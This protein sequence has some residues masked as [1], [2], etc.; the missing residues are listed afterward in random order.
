MTRPD[1]SRA[2]ALE[3]RS[4]LLL[5]IAV[6]VAF[7]WILRPF[8]GAVLWGVIIAIVFR[9]VYRRVLRSMPERPTLAALATVFVI[10]VLVILP[11][12]LVAGMLVQ[13]GVSTYERIRSGELSV[14]RY[15][16]QVFN[17]LPAWATSLLDRFGLTSLVRI[18]ERLTAILTR[19]AQFFAEQ[20]LNLGQNAASFIV[21]LFIMLYLLF[22]LLRDGEALSR[23]IRNAIPLRAD[24]QRN[25]AERFSTVI[26][27][28]VKGNLVVALVQGALGALI[29]WLLGVGAPVLWGTLMAFLSLL[30]AVGAAVVW[31]PVAIFFLATGEVG[32][33]VILIA[34]GVLVIGLV[35]NILRP[36][37]VG[38]DTRMPDYVVLISTLGGLAVF[39]LNGFVIGPVI[40]AMFISVWDIV[41]TSKA[42]AREGGH[43]A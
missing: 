16:Q 17:A 23:R 21:S 4:F 29:F 26:R 18:E 15:F 31:L 2:P 34:F 37:L 6:S 36:I 9:P 38:K 24:Q 28:T 40:A 3:D 42:A 43:A 1:S 39:G 41:A 32:K 22:F 25:L 19:S 27:A 8:Y 30:P 13:E 35:D 10:L 33:G 20:A 14:G 7:A 12:T 5:V 11:I